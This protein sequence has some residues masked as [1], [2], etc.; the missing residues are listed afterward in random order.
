MES[1]LVKISGE[2]HNKCFKLLLSLFGFVIYPVSLYSCKL[3]IYKSSF[4][5]GICCCG[6]KLIEFKS[7]G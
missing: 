5:V 3:S 1:V 2:S 6:L 4:G 7:L